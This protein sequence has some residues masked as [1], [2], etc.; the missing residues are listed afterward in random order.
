M[1]GRECRGGA[2]RLAGL[3]W[4]ATEVL[5]RNFSDQGWIPLR[6]VESKP[7]AGLL[8]L[9]QQSWKGTQVISSFEKQQGFYLPGRDGWR[10][11]EPIK[12]PTHTILFAA[13]YHVLQQSGV[14]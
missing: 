14:E 1:T 2:R 8:S 5:E 7:K 4:I 10:H 11:R 6:S 9:Q 13:Y 12:V 3:P